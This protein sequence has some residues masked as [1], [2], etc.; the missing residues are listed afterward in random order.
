M[1]ALGGIVGAVS[2]LIAASGTISASGAQSPEL[3]RPPISATNAKYFTE[4]PEAY[5]AFLAK[6]RRSAV[7]PPATPSARVVPTGSGTWTALPAAPTSATLYAPHLLTDGTVLIEDGT[8]PQWYKLTPDINGSYVNGTWSTIAVLPVINGQQ[9]APLYHASAIL[10]DGRLAIQGGEYNANQ[11]NTQNGGGN[12]YVNLG[13]IY[14]P[15]ADSW[16]PVA[17]PAN[18]SGVL[19]TGYLG[20]IGDAQSVVLSNGTWMIAG[21]CANPAADDLFNASTLGWTSTP[22]PSDQG[23]NYQDEQGYELLPNGNVLTIDVISGQNPTSAEQYVPSS[24]TWVSAGNTPVP[25]PDPAFCANGEIGPAVLRPDGTLVAF[26]GYSLVDCKGGTSPSPTDPTAIYD[27]NTNSWTQ[28]PNLPTVCGAASSAGCTTADAPAAML[29]NGNILFAAAPGY[30]TAGTHF[31][32]YGSASSGN[33]I[34]QVADPILNA[35]SK[36]AYVYN[37]VVLPNG[38]I[39][40]TDGGYMPEVYSPT[41]SPSGSWA[42]VIATAPPVVIAG[43]TY[44]ISGTQFNGLSEGADYGDD[45]QTATNYPIVQITNVA[46]NH[47]FYARTFNHSTRS[48]APG[49]ATSTSFSAP[50][51]IE[52][53]P[54]KLVV[55]ANGI[56]SAPVTVSVKYA[57]TAFAPDFNADAKS[58]ILWRDSNVDVDIWFMSGGTLASA[59]FINNPGAGWSIVGT[60]DFNGDGKSDI[61][62]RNSSGDVVIWFMNGGVIQSSA[63]LGVIPLSWQVAATGD[64]NGDGK[65]DILWRNTDGSVNVWLM[66]GGTIASAATISSLPATWIVQGIGDLNADGA[67]DI[68]WRNVNGDVVV[69]LMNGLTITSSSDLGIIPEPWSINGVADFNGDGNADILW[70]NSDGD[71]VVWFMSGGTIQSSSYLGNIPTSWFIAA[72]GDFNSDT[73]AD[74]LWRNSTTNDTVIW[75][76]NG[77]TITSSSD[78]GPV[79]VSQWT[80]VQ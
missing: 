25:L 61:L 1:Q 35:P 64:F 9:Y 65:S 24:A 28:G 50:L 13:A 46:T 17:P 18:L 14:D 4:H 48:V 57:A 59:A 60:G 29:P 12:V 52:P 76:M 79:S 21:C 37:F 19:S 80:V 30:T 77:G 7:V 36:T 20:E 45:V 49:A 71:V 10:P 69:W 3:A 11:T 67:A 63:N 58:D 73:K 53:G 32:E 40:M 55:I 51:N 66:N 78:L 2:G 41:G 68:V 74:I 27:S 15:V 38:Q 23:A 5:Q 26:G 16:T 6:L 72:T 56:P 54:S 43:D 22:A 47:V 44:Q 33:A 62:W 42:P 34:V 39:L 8:N 70:R 75:F 31:F